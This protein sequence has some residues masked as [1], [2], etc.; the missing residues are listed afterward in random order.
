MKKLQIEVTN[1][2]RRLTFDRDV[3]VR[4]LQGVLGEAVERAELSVAVVEDEE[5]KGLNRTFLGRD[6]T[7]DVIAFPY[8]QAEDCVEGE[9]VVNADEALRQ[10]EER[11]HGPEDELLLY[12]VHGTLHLLGYEDGDAQQR[13]RM[14]ERELAVLASWGRVLSS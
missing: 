10:A 5:I 7:T 4:I 12:A 11:S 8:S 14:H 6:R 3:L 9:V 1:R 2:Q 13:K